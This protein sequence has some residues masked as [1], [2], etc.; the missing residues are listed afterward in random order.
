MS[1][2]LKS[3]YWTLASN[4]WLSLSN[5]IFLKFLSDLVE[6]NSFGENLYVYSNA[7]LIGSVIGLGVGTVVNQSQSIKESTRNDVY[8][9]I[10]SALVVFF[11]VLLVVFTILCLFINI[12]FVGLSATSLYLGLLIVSFYCLDNINRS[13]LIGNKIIAPVS[14]CLILSSIFGWF[15]SFILSYLN[16]QNGFLIGMFLSI[17][18]NFIFSL[19]LVF[20]KI[21]LELFLNYQFF[22]VL[23]KERVGLS[24]ASQVLGSL[25]QLLIS[26]T[27]YIYYGGEIVAIYLIGMYIFRGSLFIPSAIQR[28]L[29][30]YLGEKNIV[31]RQALMIRCIYLN[32]AICIPFV[33]LTFFFTDLIAQAYSFNV[34]EVGNFFIYTALAGLLAALSSP[35][36]MYMTSL[37]KYGLTFKYNLVWCVNYISISYFIMIIGG[38]VEFLMLGLTLCYFLHFV[39][40]SYFIHR[41]KNEI[42]Y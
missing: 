3:T 23:F 35:L 28:I 26:S 36:G 8:N 13:F 1:G 32:G 6:S 38:R 15:V 34:N 31:D 10:N 9:S 30:P 12:S 4:V 39:L 2:I 40:G 21:K 19:S 29:L 27:L 5:I 18:V 33:L 25:P 42:S 20:R 14:I 41:L 7:I 17:L 22:C 16:I 11:L 37:N 24:L